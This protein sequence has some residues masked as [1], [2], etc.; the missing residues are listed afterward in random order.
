MGTFY[1]RCANDDVSSI[2]TVDR[3]IDLAPTAAVSAT[4][5]GGEAK[6]WYG[7][8]PFIQDLYLW[9]TDL[10]REVLVA[11]QITPLA[12]GQVSQIDAANAYP[13]EAQH[14]EADGF[15]HAPDLALAALA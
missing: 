1:Y 13:L 12:C 14:L 8:Y 10:S 3:V 2:V 6:K 7:S 11:P 5:P 15:A 4:G 9:L